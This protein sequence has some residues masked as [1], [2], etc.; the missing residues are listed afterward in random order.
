[1]RG[2]VRIVVHPD[3]GCRSSVQV[4]DGIHFEGILR[5]IVGATDFELDFGTCLEEIC[6]RHNRNV[7]L[8]D[9][10]RNERI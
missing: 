1:M 7:E 6:C 8:M 2:V 5:G 4:A 3:T 9:F 10:A